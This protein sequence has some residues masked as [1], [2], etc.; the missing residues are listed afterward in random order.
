MI[1]HTI[2]WAL[3]TDAVVPQLVQFGPSSQVPDSARQEEHKSGVQGAGQLPRA[4][5]GGGWTR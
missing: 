5:A 4:V 2:P 1:L 3:A